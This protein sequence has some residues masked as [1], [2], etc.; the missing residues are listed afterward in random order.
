VRRFLFLIC[1]AISLSGN[2]L[3]HPGHTFSE[4]SHD[5]FDVVWVALIGGAILLCLN[6]V[7]SRNERQNTREVKPH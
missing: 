1:T 2:A 5:K 4:H 7:K 6:A 3:A